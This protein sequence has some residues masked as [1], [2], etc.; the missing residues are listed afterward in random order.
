VRIAIFAKS[1]DL[2]GDTTVSMLNVLVSDSRSAE[3]SEPDDL[4]GWLIGVWDAEVRDFLP[5]GSSC[6]GRGEWHFARVLEGRAIQDVWIA[7]PLGERRS[8]R[9]FT[10]TRFGHGADGRPIRWSFSAITPSSFLWTG[11]AQTGDGWLL[12]AEFRARRRGA[13]P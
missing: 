10:A 8:L 4:Y 11:E 9:D 13:K 1:R 5:D 2:S 3:I 6:E 7:P 12:E